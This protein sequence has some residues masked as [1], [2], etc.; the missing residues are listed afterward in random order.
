MYIKTARLELKPI[1]AQDQEQV[2]KL[3]TNNI[4]NQTYMLPDFSNPQEAIP[5]FQRLMALSLEDDRYV[6]GIFLDGLL[7]GFLND[8]EIVGSC[9]EVGYA[10][11]P[12]YYN[13]GY[14][15]EALKGA[16]EYLL[17]QGFTQVIAGA[18]EENPASMR[19]MQKAGMILLERED[20]IEYRGRQHRCL[21]YGTM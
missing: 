7:I 8:T 21:Y 13:Q 10:L 6:A 19:V 11:L 20:T 5:L 12:D 15:T 17:G 3:V 9:I 14:A 18:F 1:S 4:V 2:I 16:I